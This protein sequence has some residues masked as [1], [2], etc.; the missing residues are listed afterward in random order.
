MLHPAF[1]VLTKNFSIV[2]EDAFP[3][4]LFIKSINGSW[5]CSALNPSEDEKWQLSGR[6][7]IVSA[8][9]VL[10]LLACPEASPS[11]EC[12]LETQSDPFVETKRQATSILQSFTLV[13]FL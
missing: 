11:G 3:C 8:Q 4:Y 10:E 2:L 1:Y 7:F 12:V 13:V 9:S 5:I 6:I